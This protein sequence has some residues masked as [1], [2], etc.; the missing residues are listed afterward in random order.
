[1]Y[2]EII[3]H[4]AALVKK[5]GQEAYNEARTTFEELAKEEEKKGVFVAVDGDIDRRGADKKDLEL[6]NGFTI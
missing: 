6:H 5:M 3:R 1:M 4:E 2:Q